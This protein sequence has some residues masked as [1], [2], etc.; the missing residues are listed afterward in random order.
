MGKAMEV[1]ESLD[2]LARGKIKIA[3]DENVAGVAPLL[4]SKGYKVLA[5]K[6][7]MQDERIHDWLNDENVKAF[8]TK[9]GD[10]FKILVPR[11]YVLYSLELN[12]PDSIMANLIECLMMKDYHKS[13]KTNG[14]FIVINNQTL[15]VIGGKM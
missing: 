5:P 4:R 7:G 14:K 1:I 8:F 12:R 13:I 15:K 10:D 6:S 9:N 3:V 11:K 2:E